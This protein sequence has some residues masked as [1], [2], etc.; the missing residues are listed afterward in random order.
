MGT[1]LHLQSPTLPPG[2]RRQ[3]LRSAVS[4]LG[5]LPPRQETPPPDGTSQMAVPQPGPGPNR[6]RNWNLSRVGQGA[7]RPGPIL[8]R[9]VEF[10]FDRVEQ[11]RVRRDD[12]A[13]R[14][15]RDRAPPRSVFR[16]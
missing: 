1:I 4:L 5:T 8:L 13:R 16:V 6:S 3:G 2:R 9:R 14:L 10:E 7:R 15:L 12:G 11:Q